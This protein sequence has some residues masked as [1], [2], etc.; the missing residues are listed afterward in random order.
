MD[1]LYMFSKE[2][3]LQNSVHDFSGNY[4]VFFDVVLQWVAKDEERFYRD[5]L[6]KTG[7]IV[8]SLKALN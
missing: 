4:S 3:K 2:I 6:R 7:K 8:L 1:S 5:F